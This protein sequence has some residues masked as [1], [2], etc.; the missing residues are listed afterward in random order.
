MRKTTNYGL[1]L[2]DKE[3]KMNITSEENSLNH[4]M[5]IIDSALKEKAT[6][7]YVNDKIAEAE[8][9]GDGSSLTFDYVTEEYES[10]TPCTV[11]TLEPSTLTFNGSGQQSINATPTPIDTTDI[12]TWQS[13]NK[14]I[15]TVSGG[16]VTAISNGECTI[17]ATCGDITATC[18][19]SV[20][21]I[22]ETVSV[23][24]VSLDK[25]T[26]S[27]DVGSTITLVA[28]IE[29]TNASNQNILWTSDDES[30]A[31][32]E[33]GVV[34]GK[35][36]GT[37]TICATTADGGFSAVCNVVV[38]EVVVSNYRN[39]F[40]K[41]TMVT[42]T[43]EAITSLGA[44]STA[45]DWGL[46]RVPV[47]ANTEYSLKNNSANDKKYYAGANNGAIGF[48]SSDGTIISFLSLTHLES[49]IGTNGA[50]G[51]LKDYANNGEVEKVNWLT[52]T[53]PEGCAYLLFNTNISAKADDIQLEEGDTIHDYYLPYVGGEE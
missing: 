42:T 24:G 39:L 20:S 49:Y 9:G 35:V 47:K 11:L 21:G 53:T 36:K 48:A 33:N 26:A 41:D 7:K 32:V 16:L 8:L 6:E 27:V 3:D 44:I 43:K 25:V 45:Y 38:N 4:N 13:S 17:T 46:A 30:V 12:I 40:D 31:T 1:A 50:N 22:S 28:S 19:V 29:P 15:A 51:L 37:A 2:Y 23:T 14:N 34:T 10:E 18:Q 5:E 52:F